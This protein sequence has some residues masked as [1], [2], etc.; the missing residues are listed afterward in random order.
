MVTITFVLFKRFGAFWS[1]ASAVDA[2]GHM[3]VKDRRQHM[4]SFYEKSFMPPETHNDT[5]CSMTLSS[6]QRSVRKSQLRQRM[7]DLKLVPGVM[8][9]RDLEDRMPSA[10]FSCTT[11]G[12]RCRRG[13]V[14]KEA[15]SRL[16]DI[17][18]CLQDE[19]VQVHASSGLLDHTVA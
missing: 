7:V 15:R 3:I 10:P 14:G 4:L 16:C 17:P 13:R 6:G 19:L 18:I 5:Q 12:F 2:S 9:E 8:S 1:P 11:L